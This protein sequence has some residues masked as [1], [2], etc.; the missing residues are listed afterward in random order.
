MLKECGSPALGSAKILLQHLCMKV[1]DRA[2][3]RTKVA[4]VSMTGTQHTA[5]TE[6]FKNKIN[7]T[8]DHLILIFCYLHTYYI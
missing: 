8:N 4:Q 5:S 7:K 6:Q 1:P 3:H 2:E